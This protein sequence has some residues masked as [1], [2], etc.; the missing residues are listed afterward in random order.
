MMQFALYE[1]D[2]FWE[3]YG[4]DPEDFSWFVE[5]RTNWG[6]GIDAENLFFIAFYENRGDDFFWTMFVIDADGE[7]DDYDWWFIAPYKDETRFVK[8]G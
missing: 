2:D 4:V 8:G 7:G 6:D 5:V 3:L 1:T